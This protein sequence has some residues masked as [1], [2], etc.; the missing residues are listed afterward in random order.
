MLDDI[1]SIA[2]DQINTLYIAL[3]T[4]IANMATMN[5]ATVACT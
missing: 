3:F 5:A 4:P 1:N 2:C